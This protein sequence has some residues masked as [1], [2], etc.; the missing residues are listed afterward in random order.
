MLWKFNLTPNQNEWRKNLI[1][2]L[3]IYSKYGSDINW[4]YVQS[5]FIDGWSE[6]YQKK[7]INK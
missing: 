5:A 4:I 2:A 6:Q 3:D 1:N 7:I